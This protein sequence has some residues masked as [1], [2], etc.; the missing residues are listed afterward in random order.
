MTRRAQRRSLRPAIGFCVRWGVRLSVAGVAILLIAATLVLSDSADLRLRSS[1]LGDV[2][3]Y[4]VFNPDGHGAVIYVLDG[5]NAR[6]ALV[7]ATIAAVIATLRGM[8]RPTIV[9]VHSGATRDRDFRPSSVTPTYWRPHI[10]GRALDYDRFLLHEL[11]PQVEGATN[12]SRRR[13]LM[14]HSL[15]GL[16][17]LDLASRAP[18]QFAG[19]FAFSPTISHDLS[20]VS[21]LPLACASGAVLFANWGLESERDTKT[22]AEA[23]SA[24]RSSPNCQRHRPIIRRHY[25]IV[26]QLIMVTGQVEA[27]LFHIH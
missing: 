13:H 5:Q 26:H 19:V 10:S 7:P 22:F 25:G 18:G 4:R 11:V 16:Y 20:I 23:M 3:D 24:W 1:A 6:N 21:R 12:G 15:A 14:G 2:R 27:L 17:A 9:A 8:E